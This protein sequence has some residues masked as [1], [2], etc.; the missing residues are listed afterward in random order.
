M[1]TFSTQLQIGKVAESL[2]ENYLSR[3][4]HVKESSKE[5]QSIGIDFWFGRHKKVLPVSCEVKL[6]NY[7]QKN[8]NFFLETQL[9]NKKGFVHTCMADF[10]FLCIG[11]TGECIVTTPSILR[12]RVNYW[13]K[14]YPSKTCYNKNGYWSVGVITPLWEIEREGVRINLKDDVPSLTLLNSLTIM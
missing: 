2:V 14:S 9:P 8:G 12:H 1:Y 13:Q 11:L 5:E 6:D 7:S 4:Y 10:I 3:V